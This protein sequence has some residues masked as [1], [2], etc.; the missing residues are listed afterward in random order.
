[1]GVTQW[2]TLLFPTFLRILEAL[3][4]GDTDKER[5]AMIDLQTKIA[6]AKA[7]KKF[8]PRPPT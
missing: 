1:M 2:L 8:G 7:E 4:T 6:R 5:E 3:A